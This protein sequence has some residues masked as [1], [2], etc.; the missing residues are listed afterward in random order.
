MS[1]RMLKSL[2]QRR[3]NRINVDKFIKVMQQELI[4]A[5][6]RV[7]SA[8]KSKSEMQEAAKAYMAFL[9]LK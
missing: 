8:R 1:G 9:N 7:K 2:K 5:K 6:G 3:P 4:E